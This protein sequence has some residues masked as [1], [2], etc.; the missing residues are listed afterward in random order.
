MEVEPIDDSRDDFKESDALR[1]WRCFFNSIP[2]VSTPPAPV[3]VEKVEEVVEVK[4][5]IIGMWIC[6]QT[7][8]TEVTAVIAVSRKSLSL[9]V[10]FLFTF[11]SHLTSY[12]FIL[13]TTLQHYSQAPLVEEVAAKV[14]VE[15][16]EDV[17]VVAVS[18]VV[19]LLFTLLFTFSLNHL[20]PHSNSPTTHRLPLLRK[21]LLIPS[22]KR[23]RTLMIY[24]YLRMKK[25]IS[26][27]VFRIK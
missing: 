3:P 23:W 5:P 14:A 19:I 11:N 22:M 16:E 25:L 9:F 12:M 15:E 8:A 10:L 2:I 26:T 24:Y 4:D 21:S 27:L 13:I 1:A 6:F 17:A 18:H 20:T 7:T